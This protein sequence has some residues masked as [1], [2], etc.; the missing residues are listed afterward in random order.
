M[1]QVFSHPIY[2]VDSL[3]WLWLMNPKKDKSLIHV[4]VKKKNLFIFPEDGDVIASNL[5]RFPLLI[6]SE[7]PGTVI[8]GEKFNTLN[9]LHSKIS[10]ALE[11][12]K[13]FLKLRSLYLEDGGFPIHFMLNKNFSILHPKNITADNWTKWGGEI[14]YFSSKKTKFLL[15]AAP[16]SKIESFKL[17]YK[18]NRTSFIRM[19]LNKIL[20]NGKYEYQSEMIPATDKLITF[21]VTPESSDLLLPASNKEKRMLA[22]SQIETEV[23]KYE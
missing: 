15:R 2:N 11:K 17:V 14:Q 12:Q 13:H 8:Q 6:L 5:K 22:F 18:N 9:R 4:P 21:I 23:V 1:M 20:I 10:S 19:T 7:F 16:V 3:A